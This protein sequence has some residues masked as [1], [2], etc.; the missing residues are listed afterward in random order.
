VSFDVSAGEV[1]GI[2]GET[3]SGKSTLAALLLRL[4]DPEAGRILLDGRDLKD[5]NPLWLRRHV[6]VVSQD[7]FLPC[8]SIRE[9]LLYGAGDLGSQELDLPTEADIQDAL[10]TAQCECFLDPAVF[11]K[12]LHT[13]VSPNGSKLSGGERQRLC[14]ARAL[15]KR[16]KVLLLDEATSALDEE[17]QW[18]VQEALRRVHAETGVTI[19]TIA[20]R[21][22]NFRGADR[23]MVLQKGRV[24]EM[25]SPVI[26]SEL[27]GGVYASYLARHTDAVAAPPTVVILDPATPTSSHASPPTL[28]IVLDPATPASASGHAIILDPATPE[29]YDQATPLRSDTVHADAIVLAAVLLTPAPSL[30]VAVNI[31]P[32]AQPRALFSPRAFASPPCTPLTPRGVVGS[33]V[34]GALGMRGLVRTIDSPGIDWGS[35]STLYLL[36][37]S[38]SASIN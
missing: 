38:R 9:N 7:T 25:G 13:D 17:L 3:G 20:H 5:Y 10:A 11:P 23:L 15:L 8:A 36:N 37:C 26:L 19:I 33:G 24:Q 22:S 1:F 29:A 21:L 12:G 34:L 31:S 32:L 27:P 28:A 35:F 2:L 16:P 6:A 14:I 4:Y 18:K 30:T